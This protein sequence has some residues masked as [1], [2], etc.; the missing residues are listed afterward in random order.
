MHGVHGVY[1]LYGVHG[2]Y[3]VYMECLGAWG[4]RSVYAWCNAVPA[5]MHNGPLPPMRPSILRTHDPI[6]TCTHISV[7][8]W[9]VA[10][11][12]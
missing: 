1:G 7:H 12:A 2:V 9:V 11:I 4:A 3:G 10:I 8:A 5:L 6:H